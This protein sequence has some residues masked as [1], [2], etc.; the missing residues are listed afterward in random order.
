V[1]QN[2]ISLTSRA[3]TFALQSAAPLLPWTI[4]P[5]Q[6]RQFELQFELPSTQD[7]LLDVLG[8][9][10]SLDNIRAE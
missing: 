1:T 7:A 4:E 2:D 6:F 9:T 10:F 8:Y 3:G 5:G